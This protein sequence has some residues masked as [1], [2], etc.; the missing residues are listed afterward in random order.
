MVLLVPFTLLALF[1]LPFAVDQVRH[2]LG[3]QRVCAAARAFGCRITS[4][5]VTEP[6][7]RC[8]ERE[9][10]LL[11]VGPNACSIHYQRRRRHERRHA[12][13]AAPAAVE[14]APHY[15]LFESLLTAFNAHYR[16]RPLAIDIV[17]EAPE[18]PRP[19]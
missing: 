13:A 4:C 8:Q 1:A 5:F 15:Q 2:E 18:A 6:C 10:G 12:W 17:F 19:L 14:A 11:A 3:R 16:R 9:M 7:V